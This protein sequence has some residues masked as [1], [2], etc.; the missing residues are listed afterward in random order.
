MDAEDLTAF[1]ASVR[2]V[3]KLFVQQEEQ[4]RQGESQNR[5]EFRW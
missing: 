1:A 3:F 2:P 4:Y 5:H